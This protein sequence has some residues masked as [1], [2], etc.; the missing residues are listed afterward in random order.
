PNGIPALEDRVNLLYTY[1]VKAGKMDLHTFV[2]CAST[3]AAKTFD[4]F[5]RKGTIQL[6]ADADLV[7]FD[8]DYRGKISAKTHH[9][10]V[11]YSVFEGWKIEGRPSAVTV[12][13]E[14]AVR[15]GK[16]VG[17][18]GRGKFLQRKPSHF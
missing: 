12:R 4:L 11:D 8:P 10:N 15:D 18:I 7:V 9:V 2:N 3:Q 13:G 6:G 16:F 17:K 14:V 5:P 1:G